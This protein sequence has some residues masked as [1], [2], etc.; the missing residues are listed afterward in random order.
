[1]P[2]RRKKKLRKKKN[3]VLGLKSNASSLLHAE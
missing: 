2:R 1:M 3:K